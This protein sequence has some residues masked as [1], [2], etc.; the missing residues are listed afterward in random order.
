MTDEEMDELVEDMLP[1]MQSA[2]ASLALMGV[3]RME[4]HPSMW[5]ALHRRFSSLHD[6]ETCTDPDCSA[7]DP[8]APIPLVITD[9]D[10]RSVELF[11]RC[12]EPCEAEHCPNCTLLPFPPVRAM[13]AH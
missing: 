4:V 3:V 2:M 12:F 6:E 11:V 10:G 9:D 8:E 13:D 7:D 5:P 1:A